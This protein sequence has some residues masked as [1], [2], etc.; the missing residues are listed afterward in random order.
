MLNG[1]FINFCILVT[2]TFLMSNLLHT[3]IGPGDNWKRRLASL[4][5]MAA[6]GILLMQFPVGFSDGTWFDLRA[7]LPAL[8]GISGGVGSGLLVAVIIAV[9]RVSLGGSGMVAGCII[10][11]SVGLLGG[12]L[13]VG[14]GALN[15]PIRDLL[16]R[17]LLVFG[18]S[19]LA[20]GLVPDIGVRMLWAV[21]PILIPI[22][23]AGFFVCL[24]IFRIHYHAERSQRELVRIA[25]TDPLTNLLNM[26]TFEAELTES[27]GG[28]SAH[29]LIF[30]VDR[31]KLVNDT[32]GHIYGNEVLTT[33]ADLVRGQVRSD[34]LVFRYGGEEF[35]V[36]LRHC[37]PEQAIAAA[38]R[39][40]LAVAQH[41]FAPEKG[42][43]L[44]VTISGGL[45]PLRRH[46]SV[47]CQVA[48]ADALL[49]QAKAAGR[50][51]IATT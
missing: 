18:V 13:G 19:Y 23:T 48:E 28:D 4:V 14:M 37:T 26:R 51:R 22:L 33:I 24:G 1:L 8:A 16:W 2:L 17:V 10:L 15:R 3:R 9:Y 5:A 44:Q 50:N 32:Y 36:L 42:T 11:L 45:V 39:L 34:D 12:L 41:P 47:E 25:Q 35:A 31:F 49:Y 7:V 20:L 30:D 6:C 46:I 21:F 40:R 38:E 43:P 29:L 27:L